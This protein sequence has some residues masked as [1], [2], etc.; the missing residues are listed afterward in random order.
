[1]NLNKKISLLCSDIYKILTGITLVRNTEESHSQS[2]QVN[3]PSFIK[4]NKPQNIPTANPTEN[5]N[6][7]IP[8]ISN[9]DNNPLNL[10]FEQSEPQNVQNKTEEKKEKFSFIKK[11]STPAQNIPQ[12]NTA[13]QNNSND[14][15]NFTNPE[16]TPNNSQNIPSLINNTPNTNEETEKPKSK[17]SFIKKHNKKAEETQPQQN[18][19]QDLFDMT[20]PTQSPEVNQSSIPQNIFDMTTG[21][22]SDLNPM[23]EKPKEN[24][25]PIVNEIETPKEE[26]LKPKEETPEIKNKYSIDMDLLNKCYEE[27]NKNNMNQP[28][29]NPMMGMPMQNNFNMQPNMNQPNIYNYSQNM[30]MNQNFYNQP[31][32]NMNYMPNNPMMMQGFPNQMQGNIPMQNQ[33]FQQ[34]MYFMP[35]PGMNNFNNMNNQMPYTQPQPQTMTNNPSAGENK[36]EKEEKE[37]EKK[38]PFSGL[39]NLV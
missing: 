20:Q 29:M 16:P 14:F 22:M 18:N 13:T 39:L 1:M 31:N 32:M 19:T 2:T 24:P 36:K 28:M 23:M 27:G 17:F 8:D 7:P 25:T 38:D 37:S 11:K 34:P 10:P 15:F 12:T 4:S 26:P 9:N 5:I 33:N 21:G 6:S 3:K 35:N 30:M